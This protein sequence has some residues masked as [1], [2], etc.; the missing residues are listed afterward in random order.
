MHITWHCR[1]ILC[2]HQNVL[3]VIQGTNHNIVHGIGAKLV[4][5]WE[6]NILY[7]TR[8]QFLCR[9]KD[10]SVNRLE[11]VIFGK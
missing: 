2:L 5:N 4:S 6:Q 1:E 7:T 10:I 3:M 9:K 11:S 8:W